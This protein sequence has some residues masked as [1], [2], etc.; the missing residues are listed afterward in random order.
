[1][2]RFYGYFLSPWTGIHIHIRWINGFL[3]SGPMLGKSEHRKPS[4]FKPM[5]MGL[6]ERLQLFPTTP[7]HWSWY[8]LIY[9]WYCWYIYPLFIYIYIS[10]LSPFCIHQLPG[11]PTIHQ[12]LHQAARAQGSAPRAYA[13]A[14]RR[15]C[16]R[17]RQP[18]EFTKKPRALR[19]AGLALYVVNIIHI[20]Y[21]KK[22]NIYIYIHIYI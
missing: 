21:E 12:H 6:F 11:K 3:W 15:Q 22:K 19:G 4:G 10:I 7:I 20:M 9:P 1:M 18:R 16:P 14:P 5:K 17:R 8:T 13:P 2:G